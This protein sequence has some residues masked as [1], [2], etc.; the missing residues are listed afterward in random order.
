MLKDYKLNI[1]NY[2]VVIYEY[3]EVSNILQKYL[4]FRQSVDYK[5]DGNHNI[6]TALYFLVLLMS[7]EH[8]DSFLC[9]QRSFSI[10]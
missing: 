7:C 6:Y 9:L 4:P 2:S 5:I 10:C 3:S 8:I 1:F